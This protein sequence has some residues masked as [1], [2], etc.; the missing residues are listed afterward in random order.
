MLPNNGTKIVIH[1]PITFFQNVNLELSIIDNA[2]TVKNT[3][4]TMMIVKNSEG[5]I[6]V[7][8]L[9]INNYL[10]K[11]IKISVTPTTRTVNL[12]CRNTSIIFPQTT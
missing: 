10:I 11:N 6:N 8:V 7:I 4:K 3:C 9:S 1:T 5:T 12:L 2:N